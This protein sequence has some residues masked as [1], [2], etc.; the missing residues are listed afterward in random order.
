MAGSV[1]CGCVLYR[2]K[3]LLE[4][5][6]GM[7]SWLVFPLISQLLLDC[8]TV[9]ATGIIH[10]VSIHY[11]IRLTFHNIYIYIYFLLL[12]SIFKS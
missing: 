6:A 7:G 11:G 8:T 4:D 12:Y 10:T 9:R 5:V 1:R 2:I 3:S